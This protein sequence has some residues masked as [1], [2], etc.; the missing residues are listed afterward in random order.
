MLY[1]VQ[2]LRRAL[3]AEGVLLHEEAWEKFER[4]VALLT[5]WNASINLISA[6]SMQHVWHRHLYDCLGA[7][8][9]PYFSPKSRWL[10]LGSGAG[11]PG[12]L[13]AI[14]CPHLRIVSVEQRQKKATFQA[15]VIEDLA[16]HNARVVCVDA[17]LMRKDP[18]WQQ[19]FDGVLARAV[20]PFKRLL[21]LARPFLRQG[22]MLVAFKGAAAEKEWLQTP[23][24][25]WEEW[26]HPPTQS[27]PSSS[28]LFGGPQQSAPSTAA[29]NFWL[30]MRR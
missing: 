7:L 12:L 10:D 29:G 18:L 16:L 20:A 25:A 6:H 8:R 3:T 23:G 24:C 22:G 26:F 17:S 13:L 14:G 4:Y 2:N 19:E 15:H 9:L 28:G 1:S 27:P 11:L 30:F 5:K 21:P